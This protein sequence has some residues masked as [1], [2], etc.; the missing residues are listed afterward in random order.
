MRG[1]SRRVLRRPQRRPRLLTIAAAGFVLL[2]L[3]LL[4][5]PNAAPAGTTLAP[6]LVSSEKPTEPTTQALATDDGKQP[7]PPQPDKVD[8]GGQN[9]ATNS[10]VHHE[11]LHRVYSREL[12]E[13]AALDLFTLRPGEAKVSFEQFAGCLGV[14]LDVDPVNRTE[15]PRTDPTNRQQLPLLI[16]VTVGNTQDL[17]AMICNLTVPYKYIV[18]AQTGDSPEM[19]PFFDLLMRVFDFTARLVVLQLK[20]GPGFAAAVNAGLREAL[21]HPFDE[22]P[23]VHIVHNDV[24]YRGNTLAMS[25][26][27]AYMDVEGDKAVIAQLEAE[28]KTEP[29]SY[30]PLMRQPKGLRA[31]ITLDSP[32]PQLRGEPY[33][34]VTSM[35]LPDRV[36]YMTQDERNAVFSRH[37]SFSFHNGRGE[38]TAVYL[39]RLAVL[40]VGFFDENYYPIMFDDT[41]FRWR[42]S[43]LGFTELRLS[44]FDKSIVAFD[45]DCTNVKVDGVV[46]P[47]RPPNPLPGA[48]GLAAKAAAN[49]HKPQLSPAARAL[50]QECAVAFSKAV[51]FHYMEAKW[52]VLEMAELQDAVTERQPYSSEAFSGRRHLPLDAWVVDAHRIAAV[53]RALRDT[54]MG[55]FQLAPYNPD[56]ILEAL[57]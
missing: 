26:K 29:N 39:S 55:G 7:E 2:L 15:V 47:P 13:L 37:I 14:L 1:G 34:L 23:F 32:L 12:A 28:V 33:T 45:V 50:L 54:G 27:N 3:F 10:V 20:E 19:T 46:G 52:G 25:V 24:R 38:Y 9:K 6:P 11:G 4:L 8:E 35:L 31:P 21:R 41:D 16:S 30:T 22:V 42:A 53:K 48:R 18:L 17:K 51:Q 40:T 57:K 43:L 36:R 56:I 44:E 49:D 5:M